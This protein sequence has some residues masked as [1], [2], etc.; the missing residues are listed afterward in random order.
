MTYINRDRNGDDNQKHRAELIYGKEAEGEESNDRKP[1]E[2]VLGP[3]T[4]SE[5][6]S[7]KSDEFF[8]AKAYGYEDYGYY[9]KEDMGQYKR[10]AMDRPPYGPGAYQM[11]HY[12]PEQYADLARKKDGFPGYTNSVLNY[13]IM[14]MPKMARE[15]KRKAKQRICSN[16]STTSTPSWRRGDHGKSLLCNACGLYQKLH[17]RSRPYTI[18][19]GGKT[20][21]LKGG[22]DKT[23]CVSCNSLCPTPELRSGSSAHICDNC[24]VYIK[25]Q[26]ESTGSDQHMLSEYYGGGFEGKEQGAIPMGQYYGNGYYKPYNEYQE[27]AAQKMYFDECRGYP[28]DPLSPQRAE[29][30]G[31][32]YYQQGGYYDKELYGTPE[33]YLHKEQHAMYRRAGAREQPEYERKE[34]EEDRGDGKRGVY[35]DVDNEGSVSSSQSNIKRS[36]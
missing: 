28:E 1:G 12:H 21:A 18:T 22:Y 15:L 31:I 35:S 14:G 32:G 3:E 24:L 6:A 7:V 25:G 29:Y 10:G 26:K 34:R 27:Y 5:E 9:E 17:G 16:C 4:S 30:T 20:K 23:L 13:G 33:G 2:S 19:P 36:H 8:E 11:M